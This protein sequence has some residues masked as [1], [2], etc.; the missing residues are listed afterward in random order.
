MQ[1]VNFNDSGLNQGLCQSFYNNGQRPKECH[2]LAD[3]P[4]GGVWVGI[5]K[6]AA[7]DQSWEMLKS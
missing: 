2:Y 1:Q 3:K 7:L 5:N 4:Q 6:I